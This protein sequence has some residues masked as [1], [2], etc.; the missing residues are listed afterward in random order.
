MQ[1]LLRPLL[2][3]LLLVLP[4]LAVNAGWWFLSEQRVEWASRQQE[5]VARQE[6]ESLARGW[7]F[8]SQL[9]RL[10]GDFRVILRRALHLSTVDPGNR[11]LD[12]G[13]LRELTGKAASVFEKPFPAHELWVFRLPA[14]GSEA[15]GPFPQ[16]LLAPDSSRNSRRTMA[17]VADH[18]IARTT[19][20]KRSPDT[21]RRLDKIIRALF[22]QGVSPQD[23]ALTQRGLPTPVL[24][25][26]RM[27]W[28]YWD[29]LQERGREGAFFLL[30]V[31]AD[32][33]ER[34][35]G[36]RLAL[37][38]HPPAKGSM[39]G[40]LRI[41]QNPV[42]DLIPR[43]LRRSRLFQ[44]WRKTIGGIRRFS[45]HELEGFPW[46][47]RI[48]NHRLF[49]LIV[50]ECTHIVCCLVPIRPSPGFPAELII[51]NL[52]LAGGALLILSRGWLL[53]AWPVVPLAW[54]FAGMFLLAI[55]LPMSIFIIAAGAY[56]QER[57]REGR[58]QLQSRL[59]HTLHGFEAGKNR[60]Q[61]E[62]IASFRRLLQDEQLRGL[63]A[64]D[65]LD[66]PGL[67]E[68]FRHHFQARD[69]RLPLAYFSIFDHN[70]RQV[71]SSDVAINPDE[72][73]GALRL[74]R[75]GLLG[76]LRERM[77]RQGGGHLLG[78][79]P[80]SEEDRI[81]SEAYLGATGNSIQ[82]E[83]NMGR[84]EPFI[85][86]IGRGG[87][88]QLFDHLQVNGIDRFIVFL[89]WRDTDLDERILK[90]CWNDA[91]IKDPEATF[92]AWRFKDERLERL[93]PKDRHQPTTLQR[94]LQDAAT[95]AARRQGMV[96]ESRAGTS[97]VAL[98]ARG[99]RSIV[100]AAGAPHE[101]ILSDLQRRQFEF[102]AFFLVAMAGV[103]WL[104]RKTAQRF[105]QPV[106]EL[107]TALDQV[108]AG[109]L[110]LKLLWQRPDE[111]GHLAHSFTTM[112][113]G[114]RERRQLA[115]LVSAA[116]LEA[117]SGGAQAEQ[118]L[119]GRTFPGV[120]LVSDIRGF[121][122]LCETH[123]PDE[124]TH[125]LNRHFTEMT[126]VITQ[127][128]GRVD[129][130]IGDALQAVFEERPDG[131]PAATRALNAAL[132]MLCALESINRSRQDEGTF[133]YSVGI[134]LSGG[135]LLGGA[136]G[137]R[138][139]R[140]D[141]AL[142]GPPLR[143]ATRLE[144]MGR[145]NQVCPVI[146]APEL[147]QQAGPYQSLLKPL[148][149]H[150][151]EAFTFS[152][153]PESVLQQAFKKS[154]ISSVA[155]GPIESARTATSPAS[156][157][158]VLH[159]SPASPTIGAEPTAPRGRS[160]RIRWS[161]GLACLW[162]ALPVLVLVHSHRES[163]SFLRER[164]A[165][166]FQI[167]HREMLQRIRHPSYPAVQL[168]E[169]LEIIG[170]D[171][172]SPV[173]ARHRLVNPITPVSQ[174]AS[175]IAS[176]AAHLNERLTKLGLPPHRVA[177]LAARNTENLPPASAGTLVYTRGIEDGEKSW[178]ESLLSL[179]VH[180]Y[181]GGFTGSYPEIERGMISAVGLDKPVR[182]LFHETLGC[183][184]TTE[185]RGRPAWLYWQILQAPDPSAPRWGPGSGAVS[186]RNPPIPGP[187][188]IGA[189]LV[190]LPRGENKGDELA[191]MVSEF[192]DHN[193]EAMLV[194]A[195]QSALPATFPRDMVVTREFLEPGSPWDIVLSSPLPQHIGT[196]ILEKPAFSALVAGCLAMALFLLWRTLLGEALARHLA[197]QLQAG[198]I[199]ASILPLAAVYGLLERFGVE[200]R[201]G[202]LHQERIRLNQVLD[203][204]E[205]RH[206]LARTVSESF[207]RE[208][209]SRPQVL[210]M[211]QQAV[212]ASAPSPEHAK[213][214]SSP[215]QRFFDRVYKQSREQIPGHSLRELV[216]VD[217][218]GWYRDL[219]TS[220]TGKDSEGTF[221]RTVGRLCRMVLQ[222][223][224]TT[225]PPS[226]DSEKPGQSFVG[227]MGTSIGLDILRT[228]FGPDS[229][230]QI[231]N[232]PGQVIRLYGGFGLVQLC[233][234]LVPPESPEFM[235]AWFF[236]GGHLD[237]EA[238]FR[239]QRGNTSRDALFGF[240][241]QLSGQLRH[242][243]FC[244]RFDDLERTSR[245]VRSA[246]A[247][248]STSSVVDT[249]PL[250]V[251]G[252][253][254]VFNSLVTL[255]A[256]SAEATVLAK[257][258]ERRNHLLFLL[259][260]GFTAT[261]L[262]ALTVSR[263][264]LEPIRLLGR[265]MRDIELGRY[266]AR[267]PVENHDELGDL[268]QAF[269]SMARGLEE[270][271]LM[272]RMVS[273]NARRTSQALVS[274]EGARGTVS[275][276][277]SERR[278]AV[279]M[280]AGIP[281]FEQLIANLTP[282][283]VFQH[284]SFQLS[285]LSECVGAEGG[286]IDKVIGEKVLVVF[287]GGAAGA[288][289]A[290]AVLERFVKAEATA[291]LPLGIAAGISSG[292]I[293][294]GFL[295]AGERRDHTVIGDTVNT[296]ARVEGVAEKLHR[297]R[298]LM[299]QSVVD[300]LPPEA[301]VHLFETVTVK[302]KKEALRLFRLGKEDD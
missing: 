152:H 109:N 244:G 146:V 78:S 227:E 166:D 142:L 43:K 150:E 31:P 48:G 243:R 42:G 209:S 4:L 88:F 155:T 18:L 180:L 266:H 29:F 116:A 25:Q 12:S 186:L 203:D 240:H 294:A 84:G 291:G 38:A 171:I 128:G 53:G 124:I 190:L 36:F 246:R 33:R 222:D 20:Q 11:G 260:I 90:Q 198:L 299:T 253:F 263:Q 30:L 259:L 32:A 208:W 132:E 204:F 19:E 94:A 77:E 175:A 251:E 114:L 302:G 73:T 160:L 75:A 280:I 192:R 82:N 183:V 44:A 161:I 87:A 282:E 6:L 189:F 106:V 9:S 286:D 193:T 268:A 86:N 107:K 37:A 95:A 233:L 35:A 158:L 110:D 67:I 221:A 62:Y 174:D 97:I 216:I 156:T 137:D 255:V 104:G 10:C 187:K 265:G 96:A 52:F 205:R 121:T 178:F 68:R 127:R 23:L 92:T 72:I 219:V 131:P 13:G 57:E 214:S 102:F 185:W 145:E 213:G 194:P 74:V 264:L 236:G 250:L 80:L 218:G 105:V 271:E 81:F 26:R 235:L 297:K 135:M 120:I 184:L 290:Y 207:F 126:S 151:S 51:L 274:E 293:I 201:A 167:K 241:R 65:G 211:L 258:F 301:T 162:L 179:G 63:L 122:P 224:G 200:E 283:Q 2:S 226:Q 173:L 103:L 47:E 300:L 85:Y 242:P 39:T 91:A 254:G 249:H 69:G 163:L 141:F 123:P 168:E 182:H 228:V 292:A 177:I 50:P 267:L 164:S 112:I 133:R 232:R 169:T 239:I 277:I 58:H 129:K 181:G 14:A 215:I 140:F 45:R 154:A 287:P 199:L 256:V 195:S 60:L 111:F 262:L 147:V 275:A 284:L 15:A 281:Q 210:P 28:L 55:A 298:L 238:L 139:T 196:S 98:P 5:E 61:G 289:A 295:G 296:A 125:L 206:L 170:R 229:F 113:G 237:E 100:F 252:R 172:L 285:T 16:L 157:S 279:V 83:V 257:S 41:H 130:F 165:S 276:P 99:F 143:R 197:W 17:M 176:V 117:I 118:G 261:L 231:I 40:F 46:G 56:L 119:A 225:P 234:R 212:S 136:I 217:S 1:R 202:L 108:N 66:A 159:P 3:L 27:F 223:I 247:P 273:H 24:H 269:N 138:R 272:G 153:H 71:A 76:S 8:E 148:H 79:D 144:S 22:G 49:T 230:F 278:E 64:R 115:T 270:R 220:S 134:G 188:T 93:L 89:I 7:S 288:R 70:G 248:V 101:T 59:L 34:L 191:R 21:D 149:G 245:R 54:R